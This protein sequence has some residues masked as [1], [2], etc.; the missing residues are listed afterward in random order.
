MEPEETQL[1][2]K[3]LCGSPLGRNY[4]ILLGGSSPHY[5]LISQPRGVGS[6]SIPKPVILSSG[7]GG[8]SPLLD[9]GD[10]TGILCLSSSTLCHA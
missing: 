1:R 3:V 4:P 5:P 8:S 2:D 10:L 9:A 7:L 6:G